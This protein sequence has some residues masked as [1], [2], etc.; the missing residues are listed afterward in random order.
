MNEIIPISE[1]QVRAKKW[2][3]QVKETDRPLIITQ[4]G[5][6]AAVLVS[7]EDFEGLC[8]TRDEMAHSDWKARLAR[9]EKEQVAGKV[10]A[11]EAY[12]RGRRA[13]R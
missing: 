4:R 3:D 1:L 13:K 2:V 8:A 10:T 7:C 11:L 6:P 5:K 12:V 9:A